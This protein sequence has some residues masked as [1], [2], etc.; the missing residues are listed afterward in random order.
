MVYKHSNTISD[1]YEFKKDGSLYMI[2]Q[3]GEVIYWKEG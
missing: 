1:T 2:S 3:N